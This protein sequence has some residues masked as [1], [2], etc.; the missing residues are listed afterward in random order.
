MKVA[1]FVRDDALARGATAFELSTP[2][3]E[4]ALL[5]ENLPYIIQ[6][7]G[8]LFWTS[9]VAPNDIDPKK[10]LKIKNAYNSSG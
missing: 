5:V 4:V 1:A 2:F 10:Y 6:N 7:L 3:D 8:L 9:N